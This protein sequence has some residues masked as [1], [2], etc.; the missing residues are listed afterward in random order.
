MTSRPPRVRGL[1]L[2]HTA[3]VLP[4]PA[5]APF[6]VRGLKLRYIANQV[7]VHVL[8]PT[9]DAWVETT[10]GSSP[11]PLEVSPFTS[12]QV[13]TSSPRSARATPVRA[14]HGRVVETATRE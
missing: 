7:G 11:Y 8:A 14:I 5:V 4:G 6:A 3:E 1:K 2:V 10:T 9:M 12:A 13:E